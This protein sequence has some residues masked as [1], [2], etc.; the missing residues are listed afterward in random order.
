[1]TFK[2]DSRDNLYLFLYSSALKPHLGLPENVPQWELFRFL[3]CV[4][5]KKFQ[6]SCNCVKQFLGIYMIYL[7]CQEKSIKTFEIFKGLLFIF[8]VWLKPDQLRY[9][10][11]S[12]FFNWG[13]SASLINR[14]N[15]AKN[16][17][18]CVVIF[19]SK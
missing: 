3:L 14:A 6:N 9:Q 13:F 4:I 2:R 1:M 11:S 10:M 5:P 12:M 7:L 16:S 17:S 15:K 18:C 19:W 8:R